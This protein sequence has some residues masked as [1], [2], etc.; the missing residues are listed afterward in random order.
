MLALRDLYPWPFE[1]GALGV[2]A[3][4]PGRA[5]WPDLAFVPAGRGDDPPPAVAAAL[6]DAGRL[7][8]APYSGAPSAVALQVA[9]GRLLAAGCMESVA[10]NPTLTAL[11]AALVEVVATGFDPGAITVG[12]LAMTDGGAVDPEPGFRSLLAAVAPGS[13]AGVTRWRTG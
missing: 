12:W 3:D 1:P 2:L 10:F 7:A 8:H 6:I 11:Q 13:T 5:G 9:G 4:T